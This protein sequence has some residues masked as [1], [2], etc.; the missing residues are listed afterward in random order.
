MEYEA[1]KTYCVTAYED[2]T[3]S[4]NGVVFLTLTTG[5]QKVFICPSSSATIECSS[6]KA[7][8]HRSFDGAPLGT[9]SDGG[10]ELTQS[11]TGI[12]YSADEDA[13][14]NSNFTAAIIDKSRIPKG[15]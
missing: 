13:A 2:C 14:P 9:S 15:V 6:N 4:I 7:I 11:H 5:E 1:G 3:L 8:I 12:V 10:I